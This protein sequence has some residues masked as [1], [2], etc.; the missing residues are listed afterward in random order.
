M[1]IKTYFKDY[2]IGNRNIK[3]I[4]NK[5]GLLINKKYINI[6]INLYTLIEKSIVLT[7]IKKEALFKSIYENLRSKLINGSYKGYKRFRGLPIKN[8]R[9]KTNSRTSRKH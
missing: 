1:L 6:D 5:Y 2:N 4:L 3:K 9:T 7:I 8:Q